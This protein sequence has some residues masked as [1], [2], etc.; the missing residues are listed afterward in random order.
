MM[1]KP[2]DEWTS[3]VDKQDFFLRSCYD[4]RAKNAQYA[5]VTPSSGFERGTTKTLRSAV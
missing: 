1:K 3:R 5:S 2:T 4:F